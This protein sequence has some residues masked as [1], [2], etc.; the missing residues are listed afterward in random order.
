MTTLKR[1]LTSGFTAFWRNGFLSLSATTVMTIALFVIGS[2]IFLNAL[3]QSALTSLKDKVDVNVY[4]SVGA[5][6]ERMLALKQSL[7]ARPEVARVEYI[8]RDEALARFKERHANDETELRALEELGENPLRASLAIKAKDAPNTDLQKQYESIVAFLESDNTAL[9]IDG[10]TDTSFIAKINF[11]D[12]RTAIERL[13]LIISVMEKV[14]LAITVLVVA[15]S[16]LIVFNTTRLIIY[17]ARDEIA[18][19]RLVGASYTYIRGPFMMG[20]MM[21]GFFAALIAML[22]FYPITFWLGPGTERFFGT[23]N[24]HTYYLENFWQILFTMLISGLLLGAVSSF[25][26]VKKYLKV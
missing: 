13:A 14:G 24:I 1:I 12:N 4:F 23:F 6:E 11:A 25:L 19:M 3:L 17:T 15:V 5:P 21:A 16:I 18:V 10:D 26:A 20:G 7:E 9:S 8:S 22:L 2:L